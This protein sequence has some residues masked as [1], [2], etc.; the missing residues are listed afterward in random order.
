VKGRS[1]T[2]AADLQKYKDQ[3]RSEGRTGEPPTSDVPPRVNGIVLNTPGAGLIEISL[4]SDDGLLK[5]HRLEVFR[6]AAGASTYLGRVEVLRVS[7]DR[8]VCQ[9]IPEFNRG[10]IMRGD[11][12]A[13]Q[14]N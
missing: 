5:G 1:M 3:W 2:L 13:S 10:T 7:A 4:G 8:S 12:V 14:L 11:R 9:I 6:S